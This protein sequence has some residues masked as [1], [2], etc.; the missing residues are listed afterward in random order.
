MGFRFLSV[1]FGFVVGRGRVSAAFGVG[2]SASGGAVVAGERVVGF[3]GGDD[4]SDEAVA[5]DV[6]GFEVDE[7]DVLDVFEDAFDGGES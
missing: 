3:V 1:G 7:G 5:D 4:A 2:A 6:F